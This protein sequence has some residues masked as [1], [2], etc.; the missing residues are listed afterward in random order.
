[1][2]KSRL[3]I[4]AQRKSTVA[5]GAAS[6]FIGHTARSGRRNGI[7]IFFE[8]AFHM[9]QRRGRPCGSAAGQYSIVHFKAELM[10][11]SIDRDTIT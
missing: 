9:R 11:Y 6:S 2:M 5:R 3:S 4:G 10:G 8:D 7:A 1:M